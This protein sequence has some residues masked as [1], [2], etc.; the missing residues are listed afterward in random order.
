[1]ILSTTS[2]AGAPLLAGAPILAG[3]LVLDLSRVLAGPWATQIL[4]DLGATVIKVEH[5]AGGDD[6]RGFGPPFLEL[7]DSD[8]ELSAYFISANRGKHSICIDIGQPKGVELVTRLALKADILVENFKFGDLTKKGLGYE[9]LSQLNAALIYC[10]ITGFGQTGP[11]RSR[12]GYDMVA[13][14]MAGLMSITGEPDSAGGQPQKVGVALADVMTGLYSTIAIMAALK[15]R[16]SSGLG[17]HIDMALFDVVTA[18]LANQAS[19]YLVT[20]EVPERFGNEHPN[21][22]P[23]QVFETLGGHLIVAVAN[24]SQFKKF[25]L[26]IGAEHLA[27]DLRYATNA[28]RVLNRGTLIPLLKDIMITRCLDD[29]LAMFEDS[30]VPVSPI[31]TIDRV[32]NNPQAVERKLMQEVDGVPMVANPMRF[33]RSSLVDATRP[34]LLG[35]DDDRLID[36][37]GLTAEELREFREQKIIGKR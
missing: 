29:W 11:L 14:A 15:E 13:Q 27:G 22:V 33:S 3:T 32:F 26:L 35:E 36:L 2:L 17:Q 34:P 37:L 9:A 4:S 24:D 21:I 28:K 18:S 5:P 7:P 31:N 23:Y 12:P 25:T 16:D 8:D 10:S 1:M 6:T 20:G 30:N 19:N